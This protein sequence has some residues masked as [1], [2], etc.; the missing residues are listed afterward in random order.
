MRVIPQRQLPDGPSNW[1]MF[2]RYLLVFL[3]GMFVHWVIQ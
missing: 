1:D 3:F 2:L